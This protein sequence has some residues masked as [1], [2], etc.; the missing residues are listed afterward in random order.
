MA[1]AALPQQQQQ[2]QQQQVP[3]QPGSSSSG[4]QAGAGCL[5]LSLPFSQVHLHQNLQH[6]SLCRARLPLLLLLLMVEPQVTLCATQQAMQQRC[7][8]LQKCV[9]HEKMQQQQV[10]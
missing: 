7:Q 2:Q 6:H 3:K 9:A 10:Q 1:A 4:S 8:C 5:G